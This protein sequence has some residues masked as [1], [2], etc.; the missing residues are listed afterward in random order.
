[1]LHIFIS[2][3]INELCANI[4]LLFCIVIVMFE[5]RTTTKKSAL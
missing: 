4:S 1:M 2:L 3:Q 5:I